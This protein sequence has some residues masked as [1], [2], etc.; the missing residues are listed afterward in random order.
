MAKLV[1]R[2][3]SEP[4]G[5]EALCGRTI[6]LNLKQCKYLDVRTR[7]P[8]LHMDVAH[9]TVTVPAHGNVADT[10]LECLMMNLKAG[11]IVIAD[12]PIPEFTKE[13]DKL[14]VHVNVV[15][16]N[17]PADYVKEHVKKIVNGPN[18]DGGYNKIE[19]LETLLAIEEKS[20]K[21]P[22]GRNRKEVVS[23]INDA[24]QYVTR[25]YGGISKVKS[26]EFVPA[27]DGSS[28]RSYKPANVT[29]DKAKNFLGVK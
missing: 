18:L 9:P 12:K 27:A 23:W 11:M 20:E 15:K 25:V 16:M 24:L 14:E 10:D 26:E 17:M 22:T 6:S 19:I 21:N 7:D 1:G 29:P 2:T 13:P 28:L 8:N 4:V 5:P 3:I